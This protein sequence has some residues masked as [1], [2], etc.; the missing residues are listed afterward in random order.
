MLE[1][2]LQ[3][4]AFHLTLLAANFSFS[5]L[6]VNDKGPWTSCLTFFLYYFKLTGGFQTSLTVTQNK[7]YILPCDP[8]HIYL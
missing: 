5:G 2:E 1:T 8:L 7:K 3:T 4:L 6:P